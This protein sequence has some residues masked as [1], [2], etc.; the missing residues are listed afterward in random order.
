MK[1]GGLV[2]PEGC[3]S[4]KGGGTKSGTAGL[5]LAPLLVIDMA[6]GG[7]NRGG[8]NFSAS[9]FIGGGKNI[10]GASFLVSAVLAAGTQGEEDTESALQ[11][12][13]VALGE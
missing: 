3:L 5:D 8:F 12:E 1:S 7:M 11:A 9:V 13:R 6:G 10:G 4:V 2:L